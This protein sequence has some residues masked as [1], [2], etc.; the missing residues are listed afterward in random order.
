MMQNSINL[1]PWKMLEGGNN[2]SGR[3]KKKTNYLFVEVVPAFIF[4]R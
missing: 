3:C 1:L 2:M 4:F